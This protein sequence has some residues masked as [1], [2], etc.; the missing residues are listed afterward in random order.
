MATI[1]KILNRSFIFAGITT[2]NDT[3]SASEVEDGLQALNAMLSSFSNESMLLTARTTETFTL[4]GGKAIYTVGSGQD[5]DTGRPISIVAAYVRLGNTDFPLELMNDINYMNVQDKSTTGLPNMIFYDG[6]YPIGR[7]TLHLTPVEG[8][9]LTLL[10]EKPLSQLSIDDDFDFP[11]GWEEM[12]V[13]NLAMRLS[14]EYG[15]QLPTGT[16][17]LAKES[18]GNIKSAIAKNRPMKSDIG[19]FANIYTG[20]Y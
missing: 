2:K 12:V 17:E 13:Y 7:I 19:T 15:V 14:V 16:M 5:F 9:S 6:G 4:T 18:K 11:P 3:L 10:T 8:Y 20:Y 1:R